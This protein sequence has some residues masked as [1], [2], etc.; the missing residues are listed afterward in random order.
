MPVSVPISHTTKRHLCL[1][2]YVLMFLC[3]YLR[4]P[5]GGGR[6]PGERWVGQVMRGPG[7]RVGVYGKGGGPS[8]GESRGRFT[9]VECD[10]RRGRSSGVRRGSVGGG[11]N[12]W[13]GMEEREC[14]SDE[15]VQGAKPLG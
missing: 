6:G 10:Q 4:P 13:L 3:L 9:E 11:M 1:S 14:S 15:G 2:L 7:V 8:G 12:E 5:R